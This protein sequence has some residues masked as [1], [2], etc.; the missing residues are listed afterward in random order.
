MD[1]ES[2]PAGTMIHVNGKTFC[3]PH[4][5]LP[6]TTQDTNPMDLFPFNCS[7]FLIGMPTLT[8]HQ[9]EK[10]DRSVNTWLLAQ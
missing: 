6:L 7:V 10:G 5:L 8:G 3:R 2:A 9:K 1:L 4:L